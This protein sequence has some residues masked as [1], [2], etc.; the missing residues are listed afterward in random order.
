[1]RL[2]LLA[3][4]TLQLLLLAAILSGGA[5]AEDAHCHAAAPHEPSPAEKAFSSGH[6]ADAEKL[7]R[8]AFSK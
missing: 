2:R 6:L 7:Y 4:S 1:M 8:D 5:V 3:G